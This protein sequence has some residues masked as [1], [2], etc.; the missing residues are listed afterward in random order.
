MSFRTLLI[1]SWKPGEAGIAKQVI[2]MEIRGEEETMASPLAVDSRGL[3]N[4]AFVFVLTV[5][6]YLFGK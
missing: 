6:G 3:G 5:F 1:I 2:P 4:R